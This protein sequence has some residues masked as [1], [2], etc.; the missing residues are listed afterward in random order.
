[1]PLPKMDRAGRAGIDA[2]ATGGALDRIG[3]DSSAKAASMAIAYTNAVKAP[4]ASA[5][6]G[7]RCCTGA[8]KPRLEEIP[9]CR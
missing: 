9:A 5:R 3:F 1:M 8:R 6:I 4:H 7:N 2:A